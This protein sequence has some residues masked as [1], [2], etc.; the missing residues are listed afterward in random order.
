LVNKKTFIFR[1]NNI[2]IISILARESNK[3]NDYPY[4]CFRYSCKTKDI[5]LF[6]EW[7]GSNPDILFGILELNLMKNISH[8]K[9]KLIDKAPRSKWGDRILSD[10]NISIGSDTVFVGFLSIGI[11]S[12]FHRNWT[13]PDEI[14]VGSDRKRSDLQVGSLALG[15]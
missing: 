4:I 10:Q 12:G 6:I 14:R 7:Y 11:R 3:G 13:E 2:Y 8:I 15:N 1:I 5:T 9:W